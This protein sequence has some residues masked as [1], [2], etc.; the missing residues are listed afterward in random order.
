MTSANVTIY[1]YSGCSSCRK[2]TEW[3]RGNGVPFHE[4]PIRETPPSAAELRRML[5]HQGGELRRLF[6]TSGEDY[7]AMGLKERLPKLSEA[8]AIELLAAHGNLIKRPFILGRTIG[9]TGFNPETWHV[10]FPQAQL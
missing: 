3:L 1:T 5:R 2:A 9:L 10:V 8:E 6:N 7:R 4:K